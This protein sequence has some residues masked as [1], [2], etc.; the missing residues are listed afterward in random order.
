[1]KPISIPQNNKPEKPEIKK[2]YEGYIKANPEIWKLHNQNLISTRR[3][4]W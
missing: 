1:M 2:E 3:A 4:A